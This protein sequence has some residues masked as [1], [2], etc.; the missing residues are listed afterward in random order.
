MTSCLLRLKTSAILASIGE[1]C[2]SSSFFSS[3]KSPPNLALLWICYYETFTEEVLSLAKQEN[4]APDASAEC[5]N[6]TIPFY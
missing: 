1:R 2:G 4:D 6:V 3:S 5:Q